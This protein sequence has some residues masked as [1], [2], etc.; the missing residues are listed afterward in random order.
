MKK[1]VFI[2]ADA[3]RYDY[4]E[5][6]EMDF[7]KEKIKKEENLYIKKILPSIGFCEIIEYVSGRK[8]EENGFLSQVAFRNTKVFSNIKVLVLLDKLEEIIYKI[9]KIRSAYQR[10]ISPKLNTFLQ[11]Y[12]PNEML[13]IRYRIPLYFLPHLEPTESLYE[14][15]SYYFGKEENLFYKLRKNNYTYDIEDFVKYNK[16]EGSDLERLER[17]KNKI[18]DKKLKDFTLIYIGYGELAHFYDNNSNILK[19]KMKEFDKEINEINYLLTQNYEEYDFMILGDHGMVKVE[20]Y[21]DIYPI[22][23]KLEKKFKLAKIKDY[24]YFI[25]STMF[26]LKLR[27]TKLGD[28]IFLFL[29]ESLKGDLEEKLDEYLFNFHSKYGDIKILLKPGRVFYP[30]FF[31]VKKVHGMHGFNTEIEEQAGTF[32]SISSLK[33]KQENIEKENLNY[34][35]NYILK[36]INTKEE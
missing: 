5:E 16:V 35:R 26:R 27:D 25:D 19:T 4:V 7:L 2:L 12:I 13:R 34:I 32:I 29:K 8:A 24:I 28:E 31:N 36:R 11:K 1:I 33:E 30:D 23:K 21:I 9:P 6:Y 3:F 15:D 18:K 10:Y 17:L 14:Y 22:L 20:K